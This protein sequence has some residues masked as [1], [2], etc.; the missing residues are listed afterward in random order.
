MSFLSQVS[1]EGQEGQ[2]VLHQK[3]KES[4]KKWLDRLADALN[5]LAGK[6]AE[7]LP[8]I[9]GSVFGAILSLLG[10]AVGFVAEHTWAFIVFIAGLVDVWLSYAFASACHIN[11][12]DISL[13]MISLRS[14][15]FSKAGPS[16]CSWCEKKSF[17]SPPLPSSPHHHQGWQILP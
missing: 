17:Y 8:A 13:F 2:E 1:L 15:K 11:E 6:A 14:W 10:K 12:L 5:R 7:A 3:T 4:W 16:N 9:V